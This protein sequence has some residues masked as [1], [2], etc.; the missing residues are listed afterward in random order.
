MIA[1]DILPTLRV[2]SLPGANPSSA[3]LSDYK[4][5]YAMWK[6]VWSETFRELDGLDKMFSDDFARQDEILCVFRGPVCLALGLMRWR[7]IEL[8]S[9]REDSYFQMWPAEAIDGLRANGKDIII[10]CNLTIHPMARSNALGLPMKDVM[11]GLLIQRFLESGADAMTGAMRADR[12]MHKTTYRLGATPLAT[13]L[14][15]HN[16]PVDLVAFFPQNMTGGEAEVARAVRYL[17]GV[18][19]QHPIQRARYKGAKNA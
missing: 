8:P 6:M 7:D 13:G 5:A 17:W 16:S 12:G 18:K 19:R 10:C 3:Q 14:V 4:S 1:S 11:M 9:V 15:H 2:V